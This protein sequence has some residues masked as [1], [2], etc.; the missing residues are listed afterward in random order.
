MGP[1]HRG[2]GCQHLILS[3]EVSYLPSPKGTNSED[4]HHAR[5]EH[6]NQC[7]CV[8]I[9]FQKMLS[10]KG[11]WCDPRNRAELKALALHI[12]EPSSSPGII[13]ISSSAVRSDP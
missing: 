10:K 1:Y 5:T 9:H 8:L 12:V 11:T 2:A 7:G 6:L 13:Y 4:T 3:M